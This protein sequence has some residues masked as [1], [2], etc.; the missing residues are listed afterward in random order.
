M[1]SARGVERFPSGR[2][3]RPF[4]PQ[5]SG[6][7]VASPGYRVGAG[8]WAPALPSTSLPTLS[9]RARYVVNRVC[10]LVGL[11]A[12]AGY[13]RST[14]G[15]VKATSAPQYAS[16]SI[17]SSST[18]TRTSSRVRGGFIL[19]GR[20]QSEMV[21]DA[22]DGQIVGDVGD[23]L[24]PA[25]ALPADEGVGLVHLRDQ[26]CPARSAAALLGSFGLVLWAGA[27]LRRPPRTRLA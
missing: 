4:L 12:E 6:R 14:S 7:S 2:T 9:V 17:P 5:P 26:A 27:V 19:S 20:A 3:H 13:G 15:G 11:M 23:N 25:S 22:S 21:E 1:R 16:I 10:S 24:Q 18:G 8:T